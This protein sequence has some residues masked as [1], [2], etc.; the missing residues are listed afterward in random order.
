MALLTSRSHYIGPSLRGSN[1]SSVGLC[2]TNFFKNQ[3]QQLDQ[4]L[5]SYNFSL[6]LSFEMDERLCIH[7]LRLCQNST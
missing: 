7:H 3:M 6:S 2:D 4:T 5:K 1:Q